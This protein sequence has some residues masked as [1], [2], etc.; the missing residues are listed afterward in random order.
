MNN[1]IYQ[2]TVPT[3]NWS[4]KSLQYKTKNQ[5]ESFFSSIVFKPWACVK[6]SFPWAYM[7]KPFFKHTIHTFITEK[8][9]NLQKSLLLKV[10]MEA[11]TT[12]ALLSFDGL[13]LRK[14]TRGQIW[15]KTAKPLNTSPYYLPSFL[16]QHLLI[17]QEK[18]GRGFI[19]SIVHV[20]L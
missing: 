19:V 10:S 15:R 16:V 8:K 7:I 17:T 5:D 13:L 20:L 9:K 6:F 1:Q 12:A 11:G 2:Y 3:L 14:I 4:N 18:S